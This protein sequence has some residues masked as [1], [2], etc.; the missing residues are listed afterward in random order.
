MTFKIYKVS[1]V[2][3]QYTATLN[4]KV[5]LDP[6][7]TDFKMVLYTTDYDSLIKYLKSGPII[8][9]RVLEADEVHTLIETLKV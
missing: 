4:G 3:T 2:E 9:K 7:V 6:E 8:S 1:G 5:I